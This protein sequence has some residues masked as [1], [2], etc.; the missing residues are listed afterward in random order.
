MAT[1]SAT[2][3]ATR[4]KRACGTMGIEPDS[5]PHRESKGDR[6]VMYAYDPHNIVSD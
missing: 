3:M 5:H 4:A 2:V 6:A 1:A